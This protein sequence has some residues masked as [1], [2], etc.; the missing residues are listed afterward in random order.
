MAYPTQA[1]C[2]YF[3]TIGN[4]YSLGP[5]TSFTGGPPGL[6]LV[7]TTLAGVVTGPAAIIDGTVNGLPWRAIVC[8]GG[9]T[10]I[11]SPLFYF[12]TVGVFMA[13]LLT[14][15]GVG[16]VAF[17]KHSDVIPVACSG[18]RAENLPPGVSLAANGAITGTPTLAGSYSCW[19]I[20]LD[21]E[22][23]PNVGISDL[24][25]AVGGG[26]G[27][28]LALSCG[29]PPDGTVGDPYSHLFPASGGTLPYTFAITAGALPDGLTLDAAAGAVTG[30]PTLAG[31]F[32][33]SV[34]VT[35]AALASVTV[36][37]GITIA[38]STL[39]L[40]CGGP[41]AGTAGT[42]YGPHSFP[43]TG[44]AL[45]YAYSLTAGALPNG[46]TLDAATGAAA[47]LP[48]IAGTFA[49][50]ITVMDANLDTAAVDCSI[51]IAA[52]AAVPLLIIPQQA[53]QP[54]ALPD[55]TQ[56]PCQ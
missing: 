33:F 4:A 2:T 12:G 47:G 54:V 22:N 6:T 1:N 7:G 38:D 16:A 23:N 35:D 26:G 28:P 34:T 36:D 45:P 50:Q 9:V 37:C 10:T 53:A 55:P 24:Q 5:V 49:F 44:G 14:G 18:A 39:A 46:V 51:V 15:T 32:P 40:T 11:T 42:A 29:N 41:P 8:T 43:A 31:A 17:T 27:G 20:A 25:I 48:Q 30:T 13:E 56:G 21:S 52:A 3:Y 19:I